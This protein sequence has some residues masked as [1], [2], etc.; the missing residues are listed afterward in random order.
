MRL[1]AFPK[2]I[3]M[4]LY[5]IIKILIILFIY[6]LPH[7]VHAQLVNDF[8]VNENVTASSDYG[9]R[10]DIDVE[11]NYIIVWTDNRSGRPNVYAQRFDRLSNRLGQNFRVNSIPDSS[12]LPD[13]AVYK[14]GSFGVCWFQTINFN[15]YIKL[16][17]YNNSG[18]SISNEIQLND[19]IGLLGEPKIGVNSRG[20]YIVT[21]EHRPNFQSNEIVYYQMIDSL[22]NKIGT[23]RIADDTTSRKT[24]PSI[25]VFPDNRFIIMWQDQRPPST[26]NFDDVYYQ[27]F[28]EAGNKMGVNERVNDDT[29]YMNQQLFPLGAS[30]SLNRYCICFTYYDFNT[31]QTE[32]SCQ[33]YNSNGIKNG[34]NFP[35]S[36]TI[37]SE[38]LKAIEK[39][40]DGKIIAGFIRSTINLG[41]SYFQRL[42]TSGMEIGIPFKI[43]NEFPSVSK[44]YTDLAVFGDK[45]ISVWNDSR[46]DFN[47][48][49]CNVRSFNNPDS[50][51][52]ISQ[53]SSEVPEEY[54][55]YQNYPNPFNPS[56]NIR[57]D[58]SKTTDVKL[59]VYDITGR[60]I[61]IL[62]NE[63]LNAGSYE[64]IFNSRGLSSGVYIYKLSIAGS[65]RALFNK[66]ILIK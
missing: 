47:D 20:E 26:P 40:P 4:K 12:G 30:D 48:V 65:Q 52:G 32:I 31:A 63:K 11:G 41:I 28:D 55:L 42:D 44:F 2:I 56:T 66:M 16:K 61:S 49:F 7:N 64:Y 38:N 39:R 27:M 15:S 58:L 21:W 60:E 50:T 8:K 29:V 53:I 34:G 25:N 57:F 35:V 1:C 23:N 14:N 13:I 5:H 45:V 59:S 17:L 51:V 3:V 9:G 54:K 18:K 19:S 43:S 36:R 46:F 6:F 24:N 33:L 37:D 10:I 22:G 62:V